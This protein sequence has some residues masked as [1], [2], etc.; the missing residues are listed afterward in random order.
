MEEITKH[1]LDDEAEASVARM[2][3]DPE[4]V[5]FLSDPVIQ[6]LLGECSSNPGAEVAH[7]KNA[8]VAAAKVQ[9]LVDAGLILP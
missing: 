4:L 7:L 6:Q 5:A 2:A 3:A 9:M 8:G 1:P